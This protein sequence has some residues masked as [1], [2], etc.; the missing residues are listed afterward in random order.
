MNAAHPQLGRFLAEVS[1]RV[2][3]CVLCLHH[4][5]EV[6]SE[7]TGQAQHVLILA[8]SVSQNLNL[9]LQLQIYS[10]RAAAESLRDHL[11]SALD[12]G[13]TDTETRVDNSSQLKPG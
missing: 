13:Q 12:R 4:A 8:L 6:I 11:F 7:C 3:E 1:E 5:V 9:S 2:S 10:A